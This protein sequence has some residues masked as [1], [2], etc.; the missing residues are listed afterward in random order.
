MSAPT[1]NRYWERE[2]ATKTFTHP[3]NLEWLAGNLAPECRILDYGCGYGRVMALLYKEGYRQLVG[4]DASEAMIERARTLYPHLSFVQIDPPDVPL[5]HV[6]L[7]A[8][9]LFAVLTCIPGDE[10]QQALLKELGRVVR[11]G[12]FLYI[13][14]YWIQTDDRSRERYALYDGQYSTYGIFDVA[15][16]AAVRHH[17]REWIESLLAPWEQMAMTDIK[18]T[19]MNGH[20]A[21]GF[22]WLGRKPSG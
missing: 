7:D 14:D 17:S 9:I 10:D 19:T 11:P 5:P 18:V 2:G 12:G 8:A 15:E 13:S 4:V 21:A 3:I 6:S 16:G 1:N 22:Q 20:E